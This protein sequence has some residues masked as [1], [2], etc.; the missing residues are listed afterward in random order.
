[1]YL[2][3]LLPPRC[4]PRHAAAAAA[5]QVQVN[6]GWTPTEPDAMWPRA[7]NLWGAKPLRPGQGGR[8][9]LAALSRV[10]LLGAV[11]FRG[12]RQK[13]RCVIG[14]ES[15]VLGFQFADHLGPVLAVAHRLAHRSGE[16]DGR[17]RC[18]IGDTR[19]PQRSEKTCLVDR[20]GIRVAVR[21]AAS[22]ITAQTPI[23]ATSSLI[24]RDCLMTRRRLQRLPP[25]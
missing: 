24:A 21:G 5:N 11:V 20:T 25:S 12:D 15:G 16:L 22:P 1:M 3:A 9:A 8:C 6:S 14:G 17:V 7:R 23:S 19:A 13:R 2:S 10:E 18:L 4:G